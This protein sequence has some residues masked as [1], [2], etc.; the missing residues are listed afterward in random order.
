[1]TLSKIL[2]ILFVLLI[3]QLSLA[4]TLDEALGKAGMYLKG[5]LD[6]LDPGKKLEISVVNLFSGEEDEQ[7]KK[8]KGGL[9]LVLDEFF[10]GGRVI[11]PSESITGSSVR[12]SIRVDGS[13][14]MKGDNI[15]LRFKVINL[16][17][18]KLLAATEVN[19]DKKRS[20]K[21][22]LVAVLDLET[23][24]LNKTQN[25]IFSDIFRAALAK[26]S[27]LDIASS[28]EVDKFN[29][30]KIQET[31][32]CTREECAVKIGEQLG[33]DQVISAKYFKISD[34]LYYLSA[35][36]IDTLEGKIAVSENMEHDGQLNT[37]KKTIEE[38]ALKL[39][40]PSQQARP[41]QP[42]REVV[43][44][45][46]PGG[47]F[48]LTD[49]DQKAK[50]EERIRSNW[51]QY[52]SDM[53]TAYDEVTAY[54][55]RDVKND[56]KI[57]AWER[58][59]QSFKENDPY[60]TD[61]ENML[62]Q[63]S[64]RIRELHEQGKSGSLSDVTGHSRSRLIFHDDFIDNRNKWMVKNEISSTYELSQGYYLFEYKKSK[65]SWAT[66]NSVKLANSDD[67]I[68]VAKIT[69]LSGIQNYGFGIIFGDG[70]GDRYDFVISANGYYN[71]WERKNNKIHYITNWQKSKLVNQGNGGENTL[72][73]FRQ[74]KSL[75]LYINDVKVDE[76]AFNRL[77]GKNIGFY[78][79]NK[80]KIKI[81]YLKVYK[82]VD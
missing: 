79:E 70:K 40:S 73:V 10:P 71:L 25:K 4:T 35:S 31:L 45:K 17:D 55:R 46:V 12:N 51:N 6:H 54:S 75:Y 3:P 15:L 68:I 32:K 27:S 57:M 72:A 24:S 49:L 9:Y 77:K 82:Y 78:I 48:S 60:S 41:S 76:V 80:Q 13:Y 2:C 52:L 11:L 19:F 65:D 28:S 67:F 22:T 7:A 58:F 37:L 33:V 43:V 63:A 64:S 16:M 21:K 1:M 56:L 36:V 18:G 50:A 81:D 69:K 59:A 39:V 5:K 29:P 34:K 53:K 38:L 8:I 44:P 74:G 42:Q 14:E 20:V 62:K 30:D 66:W 26:S 23:D 47:R 61:D